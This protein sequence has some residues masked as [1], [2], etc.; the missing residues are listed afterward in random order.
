LTGGPRHWN[1][2]EEFSWESGLEIPEF[3]CRA[4]R[5][6]GTRGG[7]GDDGIEDKFLEYAVEFL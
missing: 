3:V 7:Y 6:K 5:G 1:V 2:V 4:K